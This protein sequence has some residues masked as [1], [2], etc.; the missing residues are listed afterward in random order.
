MERMGA[1]AVLK[2]PNNAVCMEYTDRLLR[3]PG[4]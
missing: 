3:C 4:A 1:I 2:D